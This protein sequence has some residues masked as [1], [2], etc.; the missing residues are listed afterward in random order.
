[1]RPLLAQHVLN[2]LN[3]RKAISLFFRLSQHF[4]SYLK[5]NFLCEKKLQKKRWRKTRAWF[6]RHQHTHDV[7]WFILFSLAQRKQDFQFL[8]QKT[9]QEA[10]YGAYW[11]SMISVRKTFRLHLLPHLF[12]Y[13]QLILSIDLLNKGKKLCL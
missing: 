4:Q 5:A 12:F 10:L 13:L 8:S 3:N 11:I 1:M 2:W 9:H 6:P 7:N